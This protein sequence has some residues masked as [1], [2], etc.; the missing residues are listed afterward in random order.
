M[1]GPIMESDA[2]YTFEGHK[3]L[4]AIY[5]DMHP[6]LCGPWFPIVSTLESVMLALMIA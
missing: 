5:Y 3:N 6:L 4:I 1:Q 2:E